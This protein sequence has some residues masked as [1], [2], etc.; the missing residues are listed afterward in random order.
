MLQST[1]SLVHRLPRVASCSNNAGEMAIFS[2]CS[3]S[4]RASQPTKVVETSAS[5]ILWMT[6]RNCRA[7]K[8]GQRSLHPTVNAKSASNDAHVNLAPSRLRQQPLQ[9]TYVV[10]LSEKRKSTSA[11]LSLRPHRS[12]KHKSADSIPRMLQPNAGS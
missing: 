1:T 4:M 3:L 7:T 11:L 8:K 5:A 6:E 10:E 9:K 12:N 2:F